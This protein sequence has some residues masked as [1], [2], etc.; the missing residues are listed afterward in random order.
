MPAEL[1]TDSSKTNKLDQKW[2]ELS[3]LQK[4]T[5]ITFLESLRK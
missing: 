4:T 5:F 2:A 1:F 3:V